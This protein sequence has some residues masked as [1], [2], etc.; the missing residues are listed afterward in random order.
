MTPLERYEASLAGE[1]LAL[2]ARIPILMQ[3]AAEFIG[4]TY[5]AFASDH[6]VLV[7]ANLRCAEHFGMDQVSCISDPYR[8]TSGFGADIV[9]HPDR[10]PECLRPPLPELGDVAACPV[11]DPLACPRML[12]RV[13]AVRL[14]RRRAGNTYSILG[15]VEGPAA[16]ACD[17]HGMSEFLMD[18]M[19]E[20]EDCEALLHLCVETSLAFA[21]AQVDAGA[22]TIGVGD[23]VCSQ[24]S[25]ALHREVIFPHQQRLVE[26]IHAMGARVRLH[27]C[28]QTA[29]LW[30]SLAQLPLAI[31]DCD[32]MVDMAA[33]RSA[34]PP[35]VVLAGNH[36]P[37]S[38]LRFGTSEQIQARTEKCR[39]EA[40]PF[41]M[42][43]AGC[44]I[45]SG[46]PV[47][48]IQALCNP[49]TA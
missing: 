2:P 42:I 11:P 24:I 12:D 39:R 49:R 40:G 10:V 44:E 1:N 26:G 18:L 22:D 35:G 31:F 48:N 17:L 6:R 4:S 13:E 8:E 34:F 29:Q 20:P 43:N 41:F 16:L 19:E 27:I 25:G 15:W 32:H 28:G 7:E 37:V 14:Y 36:N 3:Y 46:T 9:F 5:G 45:P 21:R 30:P 38:D 23:A 33:A 47:E